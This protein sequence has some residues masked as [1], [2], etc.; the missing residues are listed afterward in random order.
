MCTFLMSILLFQSG[1]YG[2]HHNSMILSGVKCKGSEHNLA[3][4]VHDKVGRVFCPG[5]ENIAGVTCSASKKN[6]LQYL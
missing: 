2:G 1:T 3:D 5:E 4:C 6:Y